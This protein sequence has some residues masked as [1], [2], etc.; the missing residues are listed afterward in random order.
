MQ[1]LKNIENLVPELRPDSQAIVL[2]SN[3]ERAFLGRFHVLDE[4]SKPD[5]PPFGIRIRIFHGIRQVI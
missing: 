5:P 2:H 1:P 3:D 4:R